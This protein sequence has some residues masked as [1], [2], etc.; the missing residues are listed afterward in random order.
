MAWSSRR[1]S[2]LVRLVS[3]Y[4]ASI[5]RDMQ[6][7]ATTRWMVRSE[8]VG[9]KVVDMALFLDF[10]DMMRWILVQERTGTSK[11]TCHNDMCLTSC[12]GPVHQLTKHRW[13]WCLFGSINGG[14]SVS[15]PTC[16]H[17][18]LEFGGG[19]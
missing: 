13:K 9:P 2:D 6:L 15:F 11:S 5:C 14:G 1:S 18:A 10:I 12:T 19:H 7:A 16:V 4:V 3:R 8:D 17:A